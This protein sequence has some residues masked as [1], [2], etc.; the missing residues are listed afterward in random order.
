MPSS[1]CRHRQDKTVLSYLV[2][3][4]SAVRTEMATSQ[5]CRRLKISKQFCRVSK[6]GV[7]RVLSCPDPVSN[8]QGGYLLWRHIWKLGSRL[9]HKC[10]HTTDETGQN[11]SVSNILRTTQNCLRLSP[12]QFTPPTLTRRESLVLSVFAVWTKHE[13]QVVCKCRKDFWTQIE[14][15]Q[16]LVTHAIVEEQRIKTW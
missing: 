15:T 6:C 14:Y 4:A 10:V 9:V 16:D 3:S 8:S 7:N 1:H 11:C 12:T 13:P 5:D 2:L